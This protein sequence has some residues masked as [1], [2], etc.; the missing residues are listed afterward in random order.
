M[1]GIQTV[2]TGMQTC[3][4][5]NSR[6]LAMLNR[7]KLLTQ[8][9]TTHGGTRWKGDNGEFI[10]V[11]AVGTGNRL[12]TDDVIHFYDHPVLAVLFNSL[13]A[14]IKSPVLVVIEIDSEVAHDG[15]KG[16]C[17]Q[18][19]IV[20]ILKLPDI[21]TS[22]KAEFAIRCAKVVYKNAEWNKWADAW[23]SGKNRTRIRAHKAYIA[24]NAGAAAA[25]NAAY[26]AATATATTATAATATAYA[27]AAYVAVAAAANAAYVAAT[28]YADAAY[29][30]YA[31]A[32]AAYAAAH[33]AAAAANAYKS[34]SISKALF[35]TVLREMGLL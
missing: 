22:Q 28:V 32:N 4:N 31:A 17:K 15:L 23:L 11:R 16:G 1:P 12:C 3:G 33:A 5:V 24:A 8:D 7:Y 29:V 20:E 26:A 6:R 21:T 27:D 30:A 9:F 25:A 18:A 2:L 13:H 35:I 10:T 14:N 34:K 19:K